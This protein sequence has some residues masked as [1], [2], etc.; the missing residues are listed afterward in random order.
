MTLILSKV[1]SCPLCCN[2]NNGVR[3]KPNI[4]DMDARR[5]L[6]K[7]IALLLVIL[8]MGVRRGGWKA[9]TERTGRD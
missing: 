4:W 1:T 5:T 7:P 2:F 3:S 8:G 6:F 9:S